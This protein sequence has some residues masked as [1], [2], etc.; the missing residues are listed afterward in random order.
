VSPQSLEKLLNI[1]LGKVS[2]NAEF[3]DD[4]LNDLRRSGRTF[5]KFED[6]RTNEIEVEHLA[7][8]EIQNDC[9]ILAMCAAHTF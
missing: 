6:P 7:L 5:E 2:A 1:I 9:A 3:S 8:P 4:L